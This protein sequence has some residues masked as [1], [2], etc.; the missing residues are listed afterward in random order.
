M[1]DHPHP[2][3][4]AIRAALAQARTHRPPAD[5]VP[6]TAPEG[7]LPL[8]PGDVVEVARPGDVITDPDGLPI[9]MTHGTVDQYTVGPSGVLS[10]IGPGDDGDEGGDEE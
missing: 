3:N 6:S 8:T 1:N 4:D 2:M 7:P 5:V 10:R 9:A